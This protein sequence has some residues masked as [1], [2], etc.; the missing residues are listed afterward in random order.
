[1]K[2]ATPESV[3]D[4]L[5]S[6]LE[7]ILGSVPP[8]VYLAAH[9]WRYARAQK[10]SG[11]MHDQL[12]SASAPIAVAGDWVLEPDIYGSLMSAQLAA[13]QLRTRLES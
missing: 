1:M 5:L 10:M 4:L 8:A 12:V 13:E 7:D 9:R 11:L 2:K 6:A 3:Q